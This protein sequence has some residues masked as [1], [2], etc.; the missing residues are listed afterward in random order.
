[1]TYNKELVP[2]GKD[3]VKFNY[4]ERR[5]DILD[6]IIAAGHPKLINQTKLAQRYGKSQ[7]QISQ[8]IEALKKDIDKIMV[9]NAKL[10]THVI[11]EKALKEL[12][13]KD[14]FKAV[15]VVEK[16]NEYLFNT[17]AQKKAPDR[18][19]SNLKAISYIVTDPMNDYPVIENIKS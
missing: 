10:I 9:N 3:P 2:V 15:Q 17:G 12:V 6:L 19:E 8:D 1:M 14:I 4:I 7:S 18:V 13:E 11:F 16:W 5:A